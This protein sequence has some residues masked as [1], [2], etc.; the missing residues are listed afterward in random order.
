MG[1]SCSAGAHRGDKP[2]ADGRREPPPDDDGTGTGMTPLF[3]TLLAGNA[4]T[5]VAVLRLLGPRDATPMR[6]LHPAIAATVA[7][8]P[9]A[10]TDVMVWHAPR[11]R[12]AFPAAVA[13]RVTETR[14]RGGGGRGQ[15]GVWQ[16]GVSRD[17]MAPLGGL[18]ELVLEL[19]GDGAPQTYVTD[20]IVGT[21][22]PSLT[23]LCVRGHAGVTQGA[24]FSHLRA[25]EVLDASSTGVGPAAIASLPPTLRV[26]LARSCGSLADARFNHLPAL[27]VLACADSLM[28][29]AVVATLPP[30][31]EVVELFVIE[32]GRGAL[33]AARLPRLATL[34][35]HGARVDAAVIASLPPTL[36]N[37]SLA[38]C[39]LPPRVTSFSHLPHLRVLDC[40]DTAIGDATISSLPP[41]LT[42]LHIN[43]C[44]F[45]TLAARF[46]HLPALAWLTAA[47]VVL[48]PDVRA[49][50]AAARCWLPYEATTR[51]E[52]D[53]IT[54]LAALP[55]GVVA[56]ATGRGVIRTWEPEAVGRSGSSGLDGKTVDIALTGRVTSIAALVD[57]PS[58]VAAGVQPGASTRPG[59][60]I[61]DM[62]ATPPTRRSAITLSEPA[63]ALA[64]LTLPTGQ[65][66]L[67]V[68]SA[69]RQVRVW[70]APRGVLAAAPI[71]SLRPQYGLSDWAVLAPLPDGR[72][73]TA[74]SGTLQ[75]WDVPRARCIASTRV[76]GARV[77]SL[78][79]HPDAGIVAA[80]GD[81]RVVTWQPA[82]GLPPTRLPDATRATVTDVAFLPDG[83]LLAAARDRTL[84]VR[85]ART[86][87]IAASWPGG[88]FWRTDLAVLPPSS[89]DGTALRCATFTGEGFLVRLWR[90]PPDAPPSSSC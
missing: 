32:V 19:P 1:S 41:S 31:L 39:T 28:D 62:A 40:S 79:A 9:W 76:S 2:K 43:S 60:A 54:A 71:A 29:D 15:F 33:T 65:P 23:A 6:R 24:R 61:F 81:E 78:A 83:R 7:G 73:V 84:S 44:A 26:L 68:A 10:D 25:L 35:L 89:A 46:D 4:V 64:A 30:S 8:V 88:S 34:A 27:R 58:C 80:C 55:G 86:G 42:R 18:R 37:L 52:G 12:A 82:S 50:C 85:D 66:A 21:L 69:D 20:R 36:T 59:V 45:V 74:G 90:L 14:Q 49:A 5:A 38:L 11:W 47:N 53:R 67:A 77:M 13:A 17:S 75:V 48:A 51:V 63:M 22:P 57:A 87:A 70:A 16:L 56:L 72:L 3:V